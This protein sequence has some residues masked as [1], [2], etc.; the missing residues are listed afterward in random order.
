MKLFSYTDIGTYAKYVEE[1]YLGCLIAT[2]VIGLILLII[3]LTRKNF[4]L[5]LLWIII[6]VAAVIG[7][8]WCTNAFKNHNIDVNKMYDHYT[9][10]YADGKVITIK[11]Q[12]KDFTPATESK[13]FTLD[14]VK[15]VLLPSTLAKPP[16]GT[17]VIMYYTYKESSTNIQFVQSGTT[18][19]FT[20]VQSYSPEKCVILGDNQW[21]E[22]QYIV[23]DGENRILYIGEIA[24]IE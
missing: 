15:F 5:R 1:I 20:T 17:N 22:I 11:G 8:L 24:P 14:G 4:F 10:A 6:T 18:N 7:L 12:V 19:G 3:A 13:S 21:L 23:E 16:E 9:Q 2:G